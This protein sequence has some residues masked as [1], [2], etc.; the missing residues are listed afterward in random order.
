MATTTQTTS[1]F[2]PEV[3]NKA[4]ELIHTGRERFGGFW[5]HRTPTAKLVGYGEWKDV[6]DDVRNCLEVIR[7]KVLEQN[8]I[9]KSMEVNQR[10][11]NASLPVRTK[12][13]G[14]VITSDTLEEIWLGSLRI[15][16]TATSKQIQEVRKFIT[17][18]AGFD[19]ERILLG[20]DSRMEK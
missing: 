17:V 15:P 11:A 2:P 16:K 5:N 13:T 18:R 20:V 7:K 10:T 19:P 12:T 4:Y 14:F 6:P 3:V 9:T 8:K 1:A